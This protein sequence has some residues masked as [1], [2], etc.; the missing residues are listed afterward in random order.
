MSVELC[1]RSSVA[2]AEAG[3][4]GLGWL[5]RGRLPALDGLRGISILLVLLAHASQTHGFS[6]P[7]LI[8][9][10]AR[11]GSIGVDVFFVLSGFLI[12]L[13]LLRELERTRTVS[14]K[15]F[16]R[17]RALRILPAYITFLLAVGVITHL[18][19][20]HL[21]GRDWI[22]VLTYTVNFLEKPS[23]EIGH[24]WSLSIEEQFYLIW[25]ALLLAAG[26]RR[27]RLA[28][29]GYLAAAP[30]LRLLIWA[31]YRPHLNM[32]DSWTFTRMDSIAAG[33]LLAL[34]ASEPSFRERF[35]LSERQALRLIVAATGVLVVSLAASQRAL[36]D[37]ALGYSINAV[38][39]SAIVWICINCSQGP[40]SRF[41]HWRP[42][43]VMGTLSY[44]IYLWQQPFLNHYNAGWACRWPTNLCLAM[45]AALA[46]HVLVEAPFLRL[47]ERGLIPQPT[48]AASLV[49]IDGRGEAALVGSAAF[50]QLKEGLV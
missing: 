13:L 28:A 10:A 15:D 22:G 3:A 34:F 12:T 17:R 7:G 40:V 36:Y 42:L 43:V 25:P 50:E 30:V 9:A 38:T 18:G 47:K 29:L 1:E 14:L 16:Y 27:A 35:R 21:Q 31:C 20:A 41:L 24:V 11:H 33:C 2:A 49:D 45:V 8:R 32:V 46:S 6:S 39:I 37:I 19:L 23:W 5:S 44:S 48:S 26:K 4:T